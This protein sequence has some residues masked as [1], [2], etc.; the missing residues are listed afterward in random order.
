[1]CKFGHASAKCGRVRCSTSKQRL[2]LLLASSSVVVRMNAFPA[3]LFD[4]SNASFEVDFYMSVSAWWCN[5]FPVPTESWNVLAVIRFPFLVQMENKHGY[6]FSVPLD[7]SPPLQKPRVNRTMSQPNGL[8]PGSPYGQP[9]PVELRRFRFFSENGDDT[10]NASR[11]RSN[12]ISTRYKTELCRPYA[13]SGTCKYGDKCQFAHGIHELRPLVRHPKYKT[14]LCRTFHAIGFCPYGPRCHFIHSPDEK[15]RPR[16]PPS[17]P[18]TPNKQRQ[19][20][21][22]PE[23]EPNGPDSMSGYLP[24]PPKPMRRSVTQMQFNPRFSLDEIEQNMTHYDY[25]YRCLDMY[26]HELALTEALGRLT[27]S[28]MA[29]YSD[30]IQSNQPTT[31]PS[32]SRDPWLTDAP[33]KY[34]S[35]RRS[36]IGGDDGSGSP[37]RL[38]VFSSLA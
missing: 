7:L 31:P 15:Q 21:V 24:S 14:E 11:R 33:N 9:S 20:F 30:F 16:T 10:P 13:E 18:S 38:P 1:M 37:R 32:P 22:F 35:C 8:I 34:S 5:R 2:S 27:L 3:S 19:S 28:D 12:I 4:M 23:E 6:E 36:S 25:D 17:A 29:A 26:K